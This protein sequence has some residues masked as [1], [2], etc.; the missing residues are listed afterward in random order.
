M[1][2]LA[3][4]VISNKEYLVLYLELTYFEQLLLLV[5]VKHFVKQI[6]K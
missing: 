5:N 1:P 2:N 3:S 4:N 6:V